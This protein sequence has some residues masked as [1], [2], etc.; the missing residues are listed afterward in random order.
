SDMLGGMMGAL[1]T[2]AALWHRGRTG[3]C[4]LV[5]L[6]QYGNLAALLGQEGVNPLRRL[7][8][9]PPGNG[10]EEGRAVPHGVYRCA[11]ERGPDGAPDD[12]RWL[13]IAVLDDAAWQRL[14][15][16]LADDGEAWV[17]DATLATLD[18]RLAARAEVEARI[19]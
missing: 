6:G 19:A 14:A 13:A 4:P 18:G 5:G 3:E 17:R 1:A 16:V 8:L 11:A 7:A 2:L 10:S 12:D 15:G 9:E